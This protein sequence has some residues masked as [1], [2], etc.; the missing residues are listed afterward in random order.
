MSHIVRE[1]FFLLTPDTTRP[2]RGHGV[3][4]ENEDELLQSPRLILRPEEGGFPPLRRGLALSSS[5]SWVTH[6][7]ILKEE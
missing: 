7:R 4:I 6:Q 2:G 5:R 3:E 1:Q